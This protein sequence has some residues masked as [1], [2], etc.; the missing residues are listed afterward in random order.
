M[1]LSGSRVLSR[2]LM[3]QKGVEQRGEEEKLS[4]KDVELSEKGA[5]Q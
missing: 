4:G 5:E 3:P 2:V 1:V